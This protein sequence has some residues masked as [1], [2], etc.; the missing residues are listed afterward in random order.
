MKLQIE[1]QGDGWFW[2][3]RTTVA[4]VTDQVVAPE[5]GCFLRVEFLAPLERQER[6]GATPTGLHVVTYSGAWL[7]CRWHG[8]EI[9]VAD[10]VS[11]FMWLIERAKESDGPPLEK[12]PSAWV[13]CRV[14]A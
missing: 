9:S 11:A 13:T 8:H 2:A 10:E 5:L 7:R 6:G 4:L 12:A 1:D 3:D 14:L